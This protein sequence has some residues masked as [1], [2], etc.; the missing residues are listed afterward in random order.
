M[1]YFGGIHIVIRPIHYIIIILK[2]KK[3]ASKLD[4]EVLHS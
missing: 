2:I 3:T 1:K 4:P